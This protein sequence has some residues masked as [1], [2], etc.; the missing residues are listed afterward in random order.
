[1]T[2]KDCTHIDNIL[3]FIVS[4]DNKYL[5]CRS[6]SAKM[7]LP[8][9]N[10]NPFLFVSSEKPTNYDKKIFHVRRNKNGLYIYDRKVVPIKSE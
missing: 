2:T 7:T 4:E 9:V 5:I 8:E 10:Y 3:G 6:C 1:M